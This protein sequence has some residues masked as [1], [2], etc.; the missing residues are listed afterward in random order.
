MSLEGGLIQPPGF[1]Q[2]LVVWVSGKICRG[3][4]ACMERAV[5]SRER[6]VRGHDRGR[7]HDTGR[8]PCLQGRRQDGEN[9]RGTERPGR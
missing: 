2:L 3:S 4:V 7:S 1:R 5:R 6:G 9:S 8:S